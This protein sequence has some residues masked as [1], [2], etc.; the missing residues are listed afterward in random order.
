MVRYD[1]VRWGYVSSPRLVATWRP[2]TF[3]LPSPPKAPHVI[4]LDHPILSPLSHPLLLLMAME[5]LHQCSCPDPENFRIGVGCLLALNHPFR[6]PSPL[7]TTSNT[8]PSSAKQPQ[9]CFPPAL[10]RRQHTLPRQFLCLLPS[11]AATHFLISFKALLKSRLVRGAHP[12]HPY[13]RLAPPYPA[14]ILL[15]F[16]STF[17]IYYIFAKRSAVSLG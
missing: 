8:L 5:H 7:C 17:L 11:S 4:R 1:C 3:S 15:C 16:C 2:S 10:P 6:S 13:T 14:R 9:L 12:A